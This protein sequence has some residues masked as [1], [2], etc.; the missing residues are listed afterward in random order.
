MV[1][2]VVWLLTASEMSSAVTVDLS[3]TTAVG[4]CIVEPLE[5]LAVAVVAL[6]ELVGAMVLAAIA[7]VLADTAR[8]AFS[9]SNDAVLVLS[10]TADAML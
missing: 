8:V 1:I 2:A 10:L 9:A 6:L 3:D 4:F 5:L 7:A